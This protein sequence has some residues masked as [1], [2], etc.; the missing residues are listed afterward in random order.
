MKRATL[1]SVVFLG[2]A[3]WAAAQAPA[4]TTFTWNKTPWPKPGDPNFQATY[5]IFDLVA[6]TNK[7]FLYG[8]QGTLVIPGAAGQH[9]VKEVRFRVYTDAGNNIWNPTIKTTGTA[10]MNFQNNW[11]IS[12]SDPSNPKLQFDQTV[13]VKVEFEVDVQKAPTQQNPNPPINTFVAG[14]VVKKPTPP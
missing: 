10:N 2:L 14:T 8:A 3:G 13:D 6:G 11:L 4:G 5:P 9:Q 12:G 1:L 7:T